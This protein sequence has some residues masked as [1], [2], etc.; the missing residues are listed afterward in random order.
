MAAQNWLWMAQWTVRNGL[1]ANEGLRIAQDYGLGVRR[2]T[3]LQAVSQIRTNYALRVSASEALLVAVP[4]RAEIGTLETKSATGYVQYVTLAVRDKTTG[5]I[6]WRD[7][8]VRTDTLMSRE[9]AIDYVVGRY[10]SAINGATIAPSRWGTS[11]DEV[12]EGG[13][14][15]ATHEFVPT[16]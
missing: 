5:L 16:V 1:S 4:Q 15:M 2:A 6:T 12:V 13:M 8:S 3:W 11:P 10:R 9:A 7:Q 14:Y